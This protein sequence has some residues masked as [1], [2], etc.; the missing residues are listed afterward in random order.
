[1]K[2]VELKHKKIS[3]FKFLPLVPKYDMLPADG[4]PH[5]AE[6]E[7]TEITDAR[8]RIGR[9][10]FPEFRWTKLNSDAIEVGPQRD[11]Q[12]VT[13]ISFGGGGI[14]IELINF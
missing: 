14:A 4:V 1:M 8:R 13:M 3:A 12:L 9:A 7:L 5:I 6:D 11:R 10:E 2:I